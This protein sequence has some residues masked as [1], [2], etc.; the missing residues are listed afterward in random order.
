MLF[1]KDQEQGEEIHSYHFYSMMYWKILVS[2]IWQQKEIKSINIEFLTMGKSWKIELYRL[3]LKYTATEMSYHLLRECSMCNYSSLW[4]ML[5]IFTTQVKYKQVMCFSDQG[6]LFL[7][8]EDL[9][10][11]QK[12]SD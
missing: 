5:Q 8:A 10:N 9:W 6:S 7:D 4:S 11:I 1:P 12:L 3:T 2:A